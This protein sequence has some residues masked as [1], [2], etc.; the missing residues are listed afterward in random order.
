[1]ARFM[2]RLT[3]P[4]LAHAEDQSDEATRH[5]TLGAQLLEDQGFPRDV[6]AAVRHHHESFD[7]SGH[8]E[9]LAEEQIPLPARALRVLDAYLE[10]TEMDEGEEASSASEGRSLLASQVG[11]AFDPQIVHA[12]LKVLDR[13]RRVDSMVPRDSTE[14]SVF[15]T[16]SHELRSP[17]THLLGHS[18]L[19]AQETGLPRGTAD[20]V[21]EMHQEAVRMSRLLE[22]LLEVSSLDD[23]EGNGIAHDEV[24]MD[25]VVAQGVAR[26][27]RSSPQFQFKYV[28]PDEKAVARG[29]ELR[30][31]EVMSN[32]LDNAVKYSPTGG[33]IEVE[34]R[35]QG[36]DLVVRVADQGIGIPVNARDRVFDRF[37]RV[38]NPLTKKVRGSG[39]GLSL[40]KSIVE[41]HGGRI[42]VQGG[43]SDEGSGSTFVFTIPA[44]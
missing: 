10:A 4:F 32:L 34:L 5:A 39:L 20:R 36:P 18:E 7:G 12:F 6:V 28:G 13:E 43:D 30:L 23:G 40:C 3:R 19:L 11:R 15:S 2:G 33:L 37:Y 16:I 14:G 8:P 1:M 22:Q 31:M 25:Q 26:A 35:R 42:W 21:Q 44:H 29:D 9:G 41:A 24:D 38:Q 27:A 17:L